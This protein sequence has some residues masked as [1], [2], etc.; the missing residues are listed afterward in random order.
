MDTE[1]IIFSYDFSRR[2]GVE[3]VCI[4]LA[5]S[6]SELAKVSLLDIENKCSN[7]GDFSRV[8]F[9]SL[10]ITSNLKTYRFFKTIFLLG[11][12]IKRSRKPQICI[13]TSWYLILVLVLARWICKAKITIVSWEHKQFRDFSDRDKRLMKYIYSFIDGFVVLDDNSMRRESCPGVV[14]ENIRTIQEIPLSRTTSENI[15]VAVGRLDDN[16]AFDRLL[17]AFA[18]LEFSQENWMLH[19]YGDG[20]NKDKLE[21]LVEQLRISRRVSLKGYERNKN[22]IYGSASIFCMTSYS[23]GVPC[24]LIEALTFKI[25]V[26]AFELESYSTILTNSNSIM[27]SQKC[28]D[29]FNENLQRMVSDYNLRQSLSTGLSDTGYGK[30]DIVTRRWIGFL[31]TYV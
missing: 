22:L 10:G 7:N 13:G 8:P 16:K 1:I 3:N 4:L 14:I 21:L 27:V 18:S 20:P 31:E 29:D 25:P 26:L 6:L 30:K 9:E 17:I 11:K 28:Q 5:E 19:I 24:V 23:E 12:R 2:G 15:I